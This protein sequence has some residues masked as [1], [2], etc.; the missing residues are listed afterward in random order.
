MGPFPNGRQKLQND[1]LLPTLLTSLCVLCFHNE[2]MLSIETHLS[3]ARIRF[4]RI[5]NVIA[6]ACLIAA[7]QVLWMGHTLLGRTALCQGDAKAIMPPR[8]QTSRVLWGD[9]TVVR[10]LARAFRQWNLE[11]NPYPCY[12][13]EKNWN[14]TEILRSPATEGILFVRNMKTGSSTLAGVAIRIARA[15]ARKT[16]KGG[17]E[18][19]CKVRWDHT[20]AFLLQYGQRDKR[21]SFLWSFVRDP[22]DRAV[23]E[24]FHFGVSRRK[25][26]PSDKNFVEY[27]MDR[28]YTNNYFLQDMSTKQFRPKLAPNVTS[29][30][31]SIMDDYDF[32]GLAERM[33]ESLVI[34]KML[35]HLDMNDILYLSA[36][37]SGGFDEGGYNKTCTYIVPSFVTSGMKHYFASPYWRKHTAGDCM[38]VQVVNRSLDLTI[39]ALGRQ[40]V[41]EQ[42][43]EFRLAKA[44]AEEK[45]G[46]ST[47]YPCSAGGVHNARNHSCLWWDSGCGYKCLDGLKKRNAVKVK[48]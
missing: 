26:E 11:K 10:K 14:R 17:R 13:A 48:Q 37:Q 44:Y 18:K 21:K 35:L 28:K 39:D 27:L 40:E 9:E 34:M 29:F 4:C 7:C 1:K 32:I 19:L 25:M 15:L 6:I 5:T 43:A 16:K 42:L 8:Q 45:C 47:I 20:P 22:T 23:S 30:V 46:P 2:T 24:F 31:E 41:E 33:D 3:N 36:K 38:L 12:P